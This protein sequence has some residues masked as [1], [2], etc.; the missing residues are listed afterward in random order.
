MAT[1]LRKTKKKTTAPPDFGQP[2]LKW[3]EKSPDFIR[4]PKIYKYD[5][6]TITQRKEDLLSYV[7]P[8]TIVRV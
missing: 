5:I 1:D 3:E 6:E 4:T 2:G 7:K 8:L